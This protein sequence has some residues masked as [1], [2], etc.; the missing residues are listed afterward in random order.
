MIVPSLNG[1]V[2]ARTLAAIA[3]QRRPPDETIVVG[4]DEA[5]TLAAFPMVR[6]VD[7]DRPQSAAAARNRGMQEAGGDLLVFTDADCLPEPDWLERLVARHAAGEDVVGGSVT[8]AGESY[9]AQSDNLSMFHDFV[10]DQPAGYRPFLP[11]LNLSVRRDVVE[12][13]GGMDESFPGAAG[14]DVD[15]TIRMRRAGYRLFFEPAARVR[16][17]P[18]RVTWRDVARHWRASG[19]NMIRVRLDYAEEYGTPGWVRSPRL[20]RLASPLIAAGV[21]AGIYA[22]PF[23]WRYLSSLP[24][25]YLTKLIYCWSAA[26]ALDGAAATGGR[27]T[28]ES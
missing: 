7:T 27:E 25:V 26:E 5:G 20:L 1:P 2:L 24:V 10:P 6:F 4:R 19:R 9:W 17:A 22:R 12:R 13:V 11:S 28:Y 3:A 23:A 18:P 15:W 21:T 14:E 16:H 8:L